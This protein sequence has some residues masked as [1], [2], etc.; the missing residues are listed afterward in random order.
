MMRREKD[1]EEEKV[2][3]RIDYHIGES[4]RIKDGAFENQVGIIENID[5]KSNMLS[6]SLSMFGRS[7]TVQISVESVEQVEPS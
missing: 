1:N 3:P 4:V 2:V 6:L 7:T 5:E